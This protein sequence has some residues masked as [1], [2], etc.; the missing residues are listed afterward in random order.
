MSA[1]AQPLAFALAL[2]GLV[3]VALAAAN[4][5]PSAVHGDGYY[6]Y[7]W[8]RTIVFDGD[9][10]FHDDYRVCPD[11]WDLANA[12]VA[13]DVNYWNMGPA[14]F[15]I[16]P[17]AWDR[18]VGHPA[19]EAGTDWERAACLGPVPERAVM[20]SLV[21]G[22]LTVWLGFLGAR[23]VAGPWPAAFAAIAGGLLTSLP[24]YATTMLSYGHAASSFGCGLFFV[25]WDRW[26][27]DPTRTRGWLAMGAALGLAMLMRSQNAILAVLPFVTWCTTAWRLFGESSRAR[28]LG[29]HVGLGFAFV[30]C[31]LLVFSPQMI[32]LQLATG[33][34]FDVSQGE[35][36]MR[37]GSPRVM[38][39]LFSTG[40]G[41]FTWSPIMYPAL[42]GWLVLVARRA[43]RPLGWA[44]LLVFAMDT[45]VVASVYDWWGSIGFPGR[46]FDMLAVP[47]MYGL[48][49]LA[50]MLRRQ[51]QRHRG[52]GLGVAATLL[53]AVLFPWNAAL[54]ASIA[55]AVRV[56]QARPAPMHWEAVFHEL[57]H[58]TWKGVGNPLA[59]PASIPFALEH[60]THPRAWDVVGSQELFY[61]DHQ[62]LERRGPESTLELGLGW[63]EGYVA[64]SFQRDS[65]RLEGRD[66]RVAAPGRARIFLP[67]HWPDAGAI[68]LEVV[69]AMAGQR[70]RVRAALNGVTLGVQTV[71]G[72]RTTLRFE[73]PAGVSFHGI[74]ELTLD[75]GR[76]LGVGS[77]QIFDRDPPPTIEQRRRN[78]ELLEER[79]RATGRSDE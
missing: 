14:L 24:Y 78:A 11:P 33:Q 73:V 64:G 15:W 57:G 16:P 72:A 53:L 2:V 54:V 20:G 31:V 42:L 19:L 66:V 17:L 3:Y 49:A 32:Y 4:P 5:M 45:Y 12:P 71:P 36:Y 30:A 76:P 62:T 34:P 56:D 38:S 28:A 13:D 29:R 8:A 67:L 35:H 37:W 60:G 21:A 51:A 65:T 47:T 75:L 1:R 22:L 18:V 7:L 58:G 23:R 25:T 39:A 26:R 69:P 43:T 61:H 77:V 41:L 50:G 70:S 55:K 59:W 9:L 48:A 10:D 52:F 40:A 63:T 6:T 46:R 27:R 44:L 68:T 74:N 79:R